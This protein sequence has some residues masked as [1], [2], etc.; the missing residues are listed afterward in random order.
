MKKRSTA[1]PEIVIKIERQISPRVNTIVRTT[2]PY[3]LC[4]WWD[5]HQPAFM[6]MALGYLGDKL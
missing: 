4:A 3:C 2:N 5:L 1:Y 6:A